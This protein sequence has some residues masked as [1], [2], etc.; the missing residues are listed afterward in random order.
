MIYRP[1]GIMGLKE[2]SWFVPGRDLFGA[3]Q[4]RKEREKNHGPS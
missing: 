3:Q 2:F 4:W 1:K